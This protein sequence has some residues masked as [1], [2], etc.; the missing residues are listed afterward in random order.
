MLN[1]DLSLKKKLYAD[2]THKFVYDY[3]MNE[4]HCCKNV[5]IQ[6]RSCSQTHLK[7]QTG[8]FWSV[9]PLVYKTFLISV[10]LQLGQ[11]ISNAFC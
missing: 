4:T 11:F 3:L 7:V 10:S 9:L 2:F 5:D 8:P 1:N 6:N